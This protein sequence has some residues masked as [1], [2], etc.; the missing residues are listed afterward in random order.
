MSDCGNVQKAF[1]SSK[2]DESEKKQLKEKKILGID[3]L[4]VAAEKIKHFATI[5]KK[6]PNAYGQIGRAHV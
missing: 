2:L 5:D 6:D 4:D 1:V 3:I